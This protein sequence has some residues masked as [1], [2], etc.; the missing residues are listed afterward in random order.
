MRESQTSKKEGVPVSAHPLLLS[1]VILQPDL[2]AT[3]QT[4][5]ED[6]KGSGTRPGAHQ[7]GCR[8]GLPSLVLTSQGAQRFRQNQISCM[9]CG[10]YLLIG[11]RPRSD[12]PV[13]IKQTVSSSR[14]VKARGR[15]S[16]GGAKLT[17]DVGYTS[18]SNTKAGKAHDA[19]SR[20]LSFLH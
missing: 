15:F 17:T 19:H 16:T 5:S 10:H 2:P 14:D 13:I 6:Q 3:S 18:R 20:V 4:K 7:W 11:K 9:K 12:L 8:A 1:H